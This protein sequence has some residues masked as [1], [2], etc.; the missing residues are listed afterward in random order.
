M[1][2]FLH[3]YL[4]EIVGLTVLG[5]MAAALVSGQAHMGYPERSFDEAPAL[6]EVRFTVAE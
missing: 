2:A 5:L 6:I 3:R 1:K 4:N